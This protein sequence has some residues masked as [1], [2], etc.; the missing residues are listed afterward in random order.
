MPD[1]RIRRMQLSDLDEVMVIEEST[2]ARPWPRS[3]YEHELTANPTARYL[4]AEVNGHVAGFAGAWLIIDES[5]ITNIAVEESQRG[6]GIGRRLTA[7][8]LQYVSNLGAAY[9]TLEV[10]QS[11]QPAIS[12][13][14]S[15]GFI[16]VGRRKKYYED[17]GEDALIMVCN[18]L[19]AVED[20][21]E[22]EETLHTEV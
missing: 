8:L 15:L 18:Q 20:D 21:F 22:E 11:N 12:L 10:R 9:V 13:Y 17:N 14:T 19:P 1:C 5:H 3:S 6:Q 16:T 7:A 2:F 4:V